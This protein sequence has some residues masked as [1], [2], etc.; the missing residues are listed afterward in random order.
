MPANGE[1]T[2]AGIVLESANSAG[3][4][5]QIAK[6]AGNKIELQNPRA[7]IPKLEN[8]IAS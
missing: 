5:N 8:Q 6:S 7:T 4:E 3:R 2:F 1:A